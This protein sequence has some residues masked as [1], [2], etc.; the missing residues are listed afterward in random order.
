M[1]RVDCTEWKGMHPLVLE[2]MK[3]CDLVKE[4]SLHLIRGDIKNKNLKWGT[5]SFLRFY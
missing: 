1:S 2:I 4:Y 5:K 3:M